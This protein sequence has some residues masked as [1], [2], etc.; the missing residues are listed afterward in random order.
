MET[1]AE[2]TVLIDVQSLENLHQASTISD[3]PTEPHATSQST[4]NGI[5]TLQVGERRFTVASQT[6]ID[7]SEYFR[8]R[9]SSNWS[10]DIILSSN[11]VFFLDMDGDVFAHILRYLRSEIYPLL[12]DMAKGFDFATYLAIRHTSDYLGVLK[13]VRWIDDGRYLEAV[14]I[15]RT[16]TVHPLPSNAK[17]FEATA[18]VTGFEK[19]TGEIK[20]RQ[21]K[22]S[23]YIPH[24][25]KKKVYVC[26]RGIYIHRGNPDRC[27]ADCRKARPG[28]P[29]AQPTYE[30]ENFLEKVIA[31]EETIVFNHAI[32]MDDES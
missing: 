10:P 30:N 27:G 5:I 25:S 28:G 18:I 11:K 1:P 22:A 23:H 2:P 8:K 20:P 4:T 6:L 9:F 29:S 14:A 15:H 17:D 21:H 19:P 16:S 7:G 12:Y 31:M 3:A 13:L 26:P 32:C 24:W